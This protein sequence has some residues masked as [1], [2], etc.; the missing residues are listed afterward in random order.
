M[1]EKKTTTGKKTPPAGVKSTAADK[2]TTAADNKTKGTTPAAGTT[3]GK[4]TP[5][6]GKT[7]G[8]SPARIRAGVGDG[9]PEPCPAVLREALDNDRL[10]LGDELLAVLSSAYGNGDGPSEERRRWQ[11]GVILDWISPGSYVLDLGCGHGELLGKLI[12]EMGVH[13]QAVEVDPEA[14]MDAMELGVPVLNIDISEVLGDFRD[15]S[16]DFVIL[17]STVQTLRDPMG[18]LGQMLRVGKRCVVSFPNF[19]H[20]RTRRDLAATGRMP[21]TSS[22]P[23]QWYDTPNIRVLTVKDFL[24][25]ARRYDVTVDKAYGYCGG[26]VRPIAER[27]NLVTE[28]ALMFISRD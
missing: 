28:E 14:A 19:G 6:A 24:D 20:W 4:K 27:D 15:K 25:W 2:K 12:A 23:F 26:R 11:D 7:A 10:D 8:K 18:V 3:A 22:L 13:G 9:I 16:F 17:E 1:A 5:P 21:V